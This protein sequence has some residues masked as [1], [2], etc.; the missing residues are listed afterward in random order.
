[1]YHT[2]TVDTLK[3]V[4]EIGKLKFEKDP[5][6]NPETKGRMQKK[7]DAKD[8]LNNIP[9]FKREIEKN[10]NPNFSPIKEN[11]RVRGSKSSIMP[12]NNIFEVTNKLRKNKL[13]EHDIKDKI[14]ILPE[15][16]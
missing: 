3:D 5:Q 10:I 12:S 1:G 14:K 8:Y 4:F 2:T 7:A 11:P 13:K 15:M 9:V 6:C 16:I